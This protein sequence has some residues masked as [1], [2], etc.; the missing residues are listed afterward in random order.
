[1]DVPTQPL[2]VHVLLTASWHYITLL[3]SLAHKKILKICWSK[4]IFQ[5][6]TILNI[7]PLNNILSHYWMP[8]TRKLFNYTDAEIPTPPKLSEF[9]KIVNLEAVK[10]KIS[11]FWTALPTNIRETI[12][13]TCVLLVA[14]VHRLAR[15]YQVIM[16]CHRTIHVASVLRWYAWRHTP[17]CTRY[18]ACTWRGPVRLKPW[19][20]NWLM[21][22]L[23]D[24]VNDREDCYGEPT[25]AIFPSVRVI[26]QPS[27]SLLTIVLVLTLIHFSLLHLAVLSLQN[28]GQPNFFNT[29]APESIYKSLPAEIGSI[30][31]PTLEHFHELMIWV[32]ELCSDPIQCHNTHSELQPKEVPLLPCTPKLFYQKSKVILGQQV[33]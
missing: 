24:V 27:L 2:Y 25:K 1:M 3:N 10:I 18:S 22:S 16:F 4:P 13:F 12:T 21:K 33:P 17:C 14:I 19:S 26:M 30:H 32:R 28:T 23:S 15:H 6:W 11:A 29:W 5:V 7:P 31:Q 9:E 20:C 8:M